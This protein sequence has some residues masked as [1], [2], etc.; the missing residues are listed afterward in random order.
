MPLHKIIMFAFLFCCLTIFHPSIYFGN[1]EFP[2]TTNFRCRHT[3]LCN[4]NQHRVTA[5]TEMLHNL[6]EWIPSFGFIWHFIHLRPKETFIYYDIT[7][8]GFCQWSITDYRWFIMN[9]AILLLNRKGIGYFT[10]AWCVIRLLLFVLTQWQKEGFSHQL[11]SESE[12]V[13]ES[14]ALGDAVHLVHA[15]LEFFKRF[16]LLLCKCAV[17]LATS[18]K[19]SFS[20]LSPRVHCSKGDMFPYHSSLM[21]SIIFVPP[22][23]TQQYHRSL[24]KSRPFSEIKILFRQAYSL[25]PTMQILSLDTLRFAKQNTTDFSSVVFC[26]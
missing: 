24:Q 5:N 9:S 12:A 18:F 21:I 10:D 20:R 13:G 4:P 1:L 25:F 16:L 7:F 8:G 2:K 23:S 11:H 22:V 17:Q 14:I 19:S 6:F 26:R 15:I 3:A